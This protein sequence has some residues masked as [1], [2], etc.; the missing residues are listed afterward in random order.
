M[1]LSGTK[2]KPRRSGAEWSSCFDAT[3]ETIAA[4]GLLRNHLPDLKIRL[5]NVVDIMSQADHER[6]PS[7]R[8][9]SVVWPI[10]DPRAALP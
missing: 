2:K 7:P 3:L 6:S 5:V 1:P 8:S 10:A 9:R 4:V